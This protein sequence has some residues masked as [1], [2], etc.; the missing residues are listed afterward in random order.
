M[1]K[2]IYSLRSGLCSAL[3][4]SL[5]LIIGSNFSLLARADV[6][7]IASPFVPYSAAAA[8]AAGTGRQLFRASAQNREM[9][10]LI[11]EARANAR[12][13]GLPASG[14]IIPDAT[15]IDT[16]TNR[17]AANDEV[18][19]RY[20]LTQAESQAQ[21][22]AAADA[23]LD[24]AQREI[25]EL[26]A[27]LRNAPNRRNS[28]DREAHELLE[29]RLRQINGENQSLDRTID[30][31]E[32]EIRRLKLQFNGQTLNDQQVQQNI[33]SASRR[34]DAAQENLAKNRFIAGTVSHRAGN[35][36]GGFLAAQ[37]S[38]E[39]GFR[40]VNLTN[41]EIF[42]YSYLE[43]MEE[44]ERFETR[45]ENLP[46]EIR[47][48]AATIPG[49]ESELADLR[50]QR[51]LAPLAMDTKNISGESARTSTAAF[52]E[53]RVRLS[54]PVES[55]EWDT[56]EGLNEVARQEGI[57]SSILTRRY[58]YSFSLGTLAAGLTAAELL[59]SAA[60]G[61]IS[62]IVGCSR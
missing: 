53:E 60:S 47:A 11:S 16:A 12:R 40:S 62:A 48:K 15:A 27:E 4:A 7:I 26:E 28:L 46:N 35:P 25:R 45:V 6:C 13:T 41:R 19:V 8:A 30:S 5:V 57:R 43:K 32:D 10:A 52:L 44:I 58:A 59:A 29:S 56:R 17:I 37:S 3:I 61:A 49:L 50:S 24:R 22:V 33:E 1:S 14:L 39:L 51:K 2:L 36:L 55:V 31:A 42:G 18:R 38:F 9:R 23:E 54:A 20:Q 34:I 21:A